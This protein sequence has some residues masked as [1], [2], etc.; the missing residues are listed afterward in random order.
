MRKYKRKNSAYTKVSAE[1]RG[2]GASVARA[3]IPL[4]LMVKTMVTQVVPLQ[5]MEDPMPDQAV[6][7]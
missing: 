7:P 6:V 2:E 1:G 3:E 4:Q 5:S